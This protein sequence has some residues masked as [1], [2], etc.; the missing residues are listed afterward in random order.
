MIDATLVFLLIFQL[1]ITYVAIA[2]GLGVNI[3][4]SQITRNVG[5]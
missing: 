4:N 1:S 3:K 5:C 2:R